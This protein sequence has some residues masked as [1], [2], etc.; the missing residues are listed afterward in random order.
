MHDHHQATTTTTTASSKNHNL[1]TNS[2]EENAPLG[3]TH[4][5]GD[6]E[7]MSQG[8]V[9]EDDVQT[10]RGILLWI[11]ITLLFVNKK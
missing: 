1:L 10:L 4:A 9:E 3:H 5:P 11:H 6:S 8:I 2:D 7:Q